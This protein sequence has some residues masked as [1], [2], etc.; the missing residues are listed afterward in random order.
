MSRLVSD[1]LTPKEIDV[2][3]NGPF[4]ARVT[5]EPL[6]RGV[7]HTLGNTLRRILL[8]VLPKV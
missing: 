2:S 8:R 6:E 3:S 4:E 1:F 7:G 5:L